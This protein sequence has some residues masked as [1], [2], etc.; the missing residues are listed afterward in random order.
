LHKQTRV[1]K[2]CSIVQAQQPE[3]YGTLPPRNH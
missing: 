2:K 3:K 1:R